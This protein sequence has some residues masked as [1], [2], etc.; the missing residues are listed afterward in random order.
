MARPLGHVIADSLQLSVGYA[1]RLL[2]GIP[3]ERFARL[4]RFGG[5]VVESN[6]P[7]FVLG[8]LALYGPRIATQLGGSP[9]PPPAE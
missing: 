8:H 7:A 9:T 5:E 3:A 2:A 4:A 6:H 1:E